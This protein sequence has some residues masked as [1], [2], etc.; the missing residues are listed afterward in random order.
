MS[1]ERIDHAAEARLALEWLSRAGENAI[2]EHWPLVLAAAQVNAILALVEQ[3]R[4][5]C[6]LRPETPRVPAEPSADQ[7]REIARNATGT[8][9]YSG[10]VKALQAVW[11]AAIAAAYSQKGAD[12]G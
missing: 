4:C 6:G 3:Q 7:L 8:G 9:Y 10:G 11:R 2:R 1:S 12:R 5:H